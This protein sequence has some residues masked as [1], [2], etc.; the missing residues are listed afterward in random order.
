MMK[1]NSH[2]TIAAVATPPGEGGIA[3]IR[4]SGSDALAVAARVFRSR[5]AGDAAQ[6]GGYTVRYGKF[7]EPDSGTVVDDGLLTVFR[8]PRSYTGEDTIELSC[9]GGRVTSA[10]VL[11]LT[12]DGGARLALPGEF[13]QRAFLNGRMDLAQAEAVADVIRART[14]GAQRVAR[15]QLDGALSQA[16]I[17]LK[18]ELIG[19]VAAIEVTIDYSDEVG[20]LEHGLILPRIEAVRMEIARLLSTAERGRILREGLRVAI[21]GRP[22]VGKS[23]LLNALLR[24][25]RAIVTP[26]AGT[27]RDLVEETANI[28]G[29]P[30]VFV[31][32]A[33]IRATE[34]VVERIGVERA[35]KAIAAADAILFV[36]DGT[37]PFTE[38]D[39]DIA[40]QISRDSSAPI[41]VVVNKCDL[42]QCDIAKDED[43]IT[44]MMTQCADTLPQGRAS[45]IFVSAKTGE[46]LD[47]LEQQLIRPN[48]DN[49]AAEA[50][51]P[52]RSTPAAEA[53]DAVVVANARHKQALVAAHTSLHEAEATTRLLLPGD[54][55]AIDL[56]GALDALGQITGETVTEDIIHRIFRDFCVGK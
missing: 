43:W 36:L 7:V 53:S 10:R 25:E 16:I 19:I 9:H 32:T 54:F 49:A 40:R 56:R 29:V 28:E 6:W 38:E 20:D 5:N 1:L 24:Q 35:G 47:I 34:D 45:Y 21:V 4:V 44:P 31:D 2:D 46:S 42:A 8:G 48:A 23:S 22:N 26:I 52:S 33:G 27:T 12:L 30:V 50:E 41:W 17:R 3:V 55:I 39:A 18:D 37:A 51:Y 13:T 14:E 11:Q 15:Q